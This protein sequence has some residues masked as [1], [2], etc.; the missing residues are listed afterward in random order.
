MRTTEVK[1]PPRLQTQ[2]ARETNIKALAGRANHTLTAGQ[3]EELDRAP[4]KYRKLILKAFE[5]ASSPRKAIAANC[6][7]CTNFNIAEIRDCV[8]SRC[9]LVPYRPYQDDTE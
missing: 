6:L 7:T 3:R 5:A 9:V 2:A 1:A 8:V 4:R